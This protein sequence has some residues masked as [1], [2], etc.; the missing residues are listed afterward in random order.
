MVNV[1][2]KVGYGVFNSC[3][4]EHVADEHGEIQRVRT[5]RDARILQLHADGVS[6]RYIAKE[7]GCSLALVNSVI[8]R[9][10]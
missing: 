7:V 2:P 9:S 10:C 8:K 3:T 6:Q 5:E 1:S 4:V